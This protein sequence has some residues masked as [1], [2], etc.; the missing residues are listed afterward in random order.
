M[1]DI[2]PALGDQYWT[3]LRQAHI[4]GADIERAVEELLARG[5]PW[6]AVDLLVVGKHTTAPANADAMLQLVPR[7]LDEAMAASDLNDARAQMAGYEIGVL[8]DYLETTGLDR[9]RL[10]TYELAFYD[11]LDHYRPARAISAT[12]AAEPL[13][14][15]ELVSLV[16]R[17]KN[18]PRRQATERAQALARQAWSILNDWKGLP[19]RRQDGTIDSDPLWRWVREAR[20]AFTD[21]DRADIGDELIG[22]VLANAPEGSD[23]TWPAEPVRELIETIGSR[24]I[25]TGVHLG[26][27]NARGFTS[28]GVYDGGDQERELAE[29]YR[30]WAKQTAGA[31]PRTSRVLRGLAEDYE[32]QAQGEDA[33]AEVDAN[34]P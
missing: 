8:L 16:Y 31:W 19:G 30:R 11:L 15:V 20:L 24:S 26:V 13:R 3:R 9:Q 27:V 21:A 25:E 5:R 4:S 14:F 1:V 28:R 7:V 17:G 29:R 34:T 23:E 10:V 18:Q 2:D 33:E 32:R 22:Q 6:M 12:L